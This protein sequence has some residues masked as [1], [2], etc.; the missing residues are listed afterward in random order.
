MSWLPLSFGA[1]MVLWGLL[2]LP[3]IWWLLRLTP[4]KP[5]T[6]IFPPLKILARVLKREETPQQSPWWLTL[7]RLLMAA[8]IVAALADPVFNPREKLP[9]EG[10]ALALVIDNDWA[11]AADWGKRVATAERLINDAG[12]NGVPVVIAFTAEKANAEIGPFDAATAL[13]RLRA[14]KPRPIPTDRPAVYAR[15]AGVLETLPGAS[16]AV[17]ADGL[18][19]KGDEAAFNTLLSKNAARVV[20]ATADRLSLTGLTAADNQVDGF[21]LT[22]IRAPGDPA[23]AQVTAGAFDDKGRRI[24]DATL[25]FSPGET[26]ATGTMAV[27]FELRNDF[28]SIALDGERQAGAVRV[29]DESSKRRRVGLLSQAE[30]DQAQPLLSPLYYIR[31]ALQPFADLVEPSSADLADAIPQILDQK[32]AMIVMADIGTIP[33]Q[34]RQRLVDWVDNGGTLVRFAGSRLA[35]AGDDDDLLP[36]RL[37]TG[38]R[39]LGGALSWTSPQPVTEFPKAGPFADLA[40]PTEVT[41][42]RQVLAE[43][44][45][46]IVERTWAALA[47]GTPL[48]TGLKKGKG[49]LVLFHVTPEATWSNLPI[50][51]SFVE[52]LRRIVQLSRNQGAAIA[53]AEAAA[54]SLAPYRMIAADG[55]LVPPTP[56]ARP[57]VPG[58]GALPVTFENPPGL[59]GSETGVFAHNLLEADSTLAPLARPQI[60]V[61][62]TSI[63]YAFDE[64]RN[65]KGALVAAALVL[66]LLDTLAVF[67]MGGLFSRRPRRAGAMATTAAVLIALGSLFGHADLARADDAKPGDEIAIEAISKTRIAYVLT[68]VPGDDSIS[69]AGLEGLTRFLVEKTALEPGAPAGVDISKDELSFYPLI[70]WPIDPAAPMPSQAAIARI[71]AYMQQGGTVLFDTRD[72]F[73]NGIGA[74]STSPATERLRDILGNLN[75]PPLEPVPSDHVLTKSFFILPEFPGR[76]AGSPLWVEASLDASNAENRPVRTGDGVSPI[77]ITANDFAGAWA[78]DENGDPLLP[79][80]P[81]DPMQR[82]YALRAGVNIM[83]YMLTGNYKSDQVHVPILLERLGQ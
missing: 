30:A 1:P 51:G 35:T 54:A 49:T 62:V 31:R 77:M 23:P 57:L 53:N 33:G 60:T 46:D 56:D 20:W 61:P 70:Y 71:D 43:P 27:P 22:A 25:T 24:A 64:S 3:V 36:V 82:V 79:T 10:A 78:V 14:A 13:D 73:A 81:A 38:E 50:S 69:R 59:Y 44:T 7:L 9:A 66:M 29:L 48:V 21:A 55:S 63:Q 32:P 17:L 4:P 80:V 67:W 12:S 19:A 65:L 16:V 58:T 34:V 45:P 11:S 52:M 68:G 41:V 47:D 76:F 5:Q 15:V 72:Q 42:S 8:L 37:R 26:T 39:S 6:E 40:P 2:A 18:A 28:A 75:V 74:D 83:M